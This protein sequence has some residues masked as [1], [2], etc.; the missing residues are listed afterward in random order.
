MFKIQ[1][2]LV[3]LLLISSIFFSTSQSLISQIRTQS[4]LFIAENTIIGIP[5]TLIFGNAGDGGNI[6]TA[7]TGNKGYLV[8]G[9]KGKWIGASDHQFVDGYV[10][11]LHNNAFVFPIGENG[12][13]H[14]IAISGASGTSA[15]YFDKKPSKFDKQNSKKEITPETPETLLIQNGYWALDG[16]QPTGITLM[17]NYKM[18]VNNL[19]IDELSSMSIMGLRNDQWEIIS[20]AVDKYAYDESTHNLVSTQ[21]KSSF[22]KGT[23]STT[24]AIIPNQYEYFTIG[25]VKQVKSEGKLAIYP[26][27]VAMNLPVTVSYEFPSEEEAT[28]QVHNANGALVKELSLQV[29][30]GV[31]KLSEL[32][33]VAGTYTL[34]IVFPEGNTIT[35]RLLI[36]EK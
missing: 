10:K 1:I 3:K 28:L 27:P 18:D 20:S 12:N 13:Y 26:N 14:P 36:I 21:Q 5:N 23:I 29:N 33:N 17:W 6:S 11:V 30:N 31:L 16:D 4:N 32:T 2:N 8:F 22:D 24:T 7:K 25:A 9:P 34:R 19:A 15:A 35:E